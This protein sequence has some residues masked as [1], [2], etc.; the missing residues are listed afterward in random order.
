MEAPPVWGSASNMFYRVS[1][2]VRCAG[3]HVYQSGQIVC[4]QLSAL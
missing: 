4:N 3:R 2:E 1:R